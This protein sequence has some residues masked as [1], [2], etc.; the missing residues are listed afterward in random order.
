MGTID[1]NRRSWDIANRKY[2]EETTAL[3]AT[4]AHSTLLGVEEALLAPLLDRSI[5]LHLQSGDGIDDAALCHLGAATVVGVDSS[6]V[7]TATA[8]GRA[9]A[10]GLPISYVVADARVL[11]MRSS[12]A[13]LVY[14]GKGAYMWLP[15]LESWTT[16]IE[17][18]LRPGGHLFI[19]DAHPA[20]SLW[21][22]DEDEACIRGD[23]SYFGGTRTNDSSP[24][25]AIERFSPGTD[26][27]ATEWQWTLADVVTAI[28]RAGL[29][30]QHLGEHSE[31]FWR[32]TD[33]GAVAAWTGR[34]PN[35]FSLLASKPSS[36][37]QC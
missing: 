25:S 19:Y 29:Q 23:R 15:D 14:T 2:V 5:V 32:P 33:A 21:T 4:A 9:D 8:R 30:L 36:A 34:L 11:P 3:L 13:D 37:G 17:R 27:V 26:D 7:A 28:L 6:P 16:E 22:W 10:L 31:P 20:A 24:A 12:S 18:V 1:D 35:S